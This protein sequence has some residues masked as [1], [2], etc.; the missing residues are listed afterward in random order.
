MRKWFFRN[1]K[2]F[3]EKA[4]HFYEY[5]RNCHE[6]ADTK[7]WNV[8]KIFAKFRNNLRNF[9][10][11]WKKALVN[12]DILFYFNDSCFV[13][14][15]DQNFISTSSLNSKNGTFSAPIFLNPEGH[16]RQCT[17]NFRFVFLSILFSTYLSCY[18]LNPESHVRQCTTTSGMSFF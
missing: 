14:A 9:A 6:N 8:Q 4:K 18:L 7:L 13:S 10:W 1:A 12:F 2:H 17:Y 16:V 3:H 15:C 5:A 11:K